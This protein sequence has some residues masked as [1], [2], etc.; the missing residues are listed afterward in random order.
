TEESF[1]SLLEL[2]WSGQKELDV[3]GKKRKF[4]DDG[5]EIIMTGYC[6]GDGYCV[7]FGEATGKILPAK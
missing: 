4:I 3:S 1:G 5:D 7:G 6:Q 2:T